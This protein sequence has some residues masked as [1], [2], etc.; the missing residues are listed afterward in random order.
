M[1]YI[2]KSPILKRLLAAVESLT[3]LLL[4]SGD[5]LPGKRLRFL[6]IGVGNTF[7]LLGINLALLLNFPQYE[8]ILLFLFGVFILAGIGLLFAISFAFRRYLLHPSEELKHWSDEIREG[9][10]E[11]RLFPDEMGEL[12]EVSKD[13][14]NL[15]D[16]LQNISRHMDDEIKRQT[17]RFEQKTNSLQV[18]YDVAASLNASRDLKDLL[19]RFLHTMRDIVNAKAGTVRLLTDKNQMELVASIGLEDAVVEEERLVPVQRCL[20]GNAVTEGEVLFQQDIT[21]CNR[22]VGR[23]MLGGPDL[24]MIAVPLQYHGKNLGVYNLFVEKAD[25]DSR[26]EVKAL[27]TSIGRHLGMA[28]EKAHLDDEAKRLSIIKERNAI[29]HELHDS[30]AQTLAS[31][32]FQVSMLDEAIDQQGADVTHE[33][34]QQI[35]SGLNDAYTELR[36]LLAHFRAPINS[37][38]LLP[39]LEDLISNFRKQTGM[40]VLLQKE[41][42]STR[43]SANSEMQVL[44]IIQEALAN[45]RKHSG[46][47]TV[48][49]LLRCDKE[50]NYHI[51]VE[52]DGIGMEKP[53]FSGHPGEHLGMSI[54][55]ERARYLGG[56]LRIESEAGEGT[57]V[58]LTFSNPNSAE[59]KE[60]EPQHFALI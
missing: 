47:H 38:G 44:R 51:L 13:I 22:W 12:K 14:N 41:W 45:V 8:E 6:L 10:I 29:A 4:L 18:L 34:I 9:N 37:R 30:L 28:I 39:A 1:G 53:A 46:A 27:F 36:E 35:K 32:R 59:A 54:M 20:C 5:A 3:A 55:K 56:D 15:L 16:Y 23:P 33:D 21:P 52:D 50:D 7:A 24:E 43:L 17:K 49:V 26:D 2:E 11:V 57:R 48:R 42:D 60:K 25:I 40:H 58:Q 31:L 19:T